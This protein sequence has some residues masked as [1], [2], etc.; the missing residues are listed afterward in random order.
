MTRVNFTHTS[1]TLKER[2]RN[3]AVRKTRPTWAAW[4]V[5]TV[6]D[7]SSS[8]RGWKSLRLPAPDSLPS[9]GRRCT[10]LKQKMLIYNSNVKSDLPLVG[11]LASGQSRHSEAGSAPQTH[12]CLRQI[13]RIF[14]PNRVSNS[15][16]YKK[17][18]SYQDQHRAESE[19]GRFCAEAGAAAHPKKKQGDP[20]STWRRTVKQEPVL[21]MNLSWGRSPPCCQGPGSV[22]R[23]RSSLM[24][25]WGCRGVSKCNRE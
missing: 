5:W 22:E 13:C 24:S 4:L 6:G 20:R 7:Q 8:R 2:F 3:R 16:L 17:P 12:F 11:A 25:L 9:G 18:K 10:A 15:E 23:A 19:V 1:R 14:W 21:E